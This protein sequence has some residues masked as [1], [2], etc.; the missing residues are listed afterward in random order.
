MNKYT[1]RVRGENYLWGSAGLLLNF[2][3]PLLLLVQVDL[4]GEPIRLFT[5]TKDGPASRVS[6]GTL[7]RGET[8]TVSLQTLRGVIAQCDLNSDVDC[9]IYHIHGSD[10]IAQNRLSTGSGPGT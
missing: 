8:F 7:N 5:E 10:A 9:T 3:L 4:F 6:L 2:D 1:V